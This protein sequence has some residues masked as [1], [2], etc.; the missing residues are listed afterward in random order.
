M[1]GKCG[2]FWPHDVLTIV[3]SDSAGSCGLSPST[4]TESLRS[5]L[6]D[7]FSENRHHVTNL[8]G[9]LAAETYIYDTLK[10]YGMQIY[11]DEFDSEYSGYKGKNIVGIWRGTGTPELRPKQDKPVILGAH[12]DTCRNDPGVDENG[13][14]VAAL[15]EAA[16]VISSLPCL[17]VHSVV[18]AFFDLKCNESGADKAACADGQCGSEHFVEQ[19][20]VPY[21]GY[22][23]VKLSD[24]QGVI[25]M[26]TVLNYNN[27]KGSQ[28][29]PE[30]FENTPLWDEVYVEEEADGMRGNF[31]GIFT[32]QLYDQPLYSI[33]HN[34]WDEE[35]DPQYKRRDV[36]FPY[37]NIAEEADTSTDP[38]WNLYQIGSQDLGS[39]WKASGDIKGLLLSDTA[40]A[41]HRDVGSNEKLPLTNERLGFLKKITNVVI[42]TTMDLAGGRERCHPD[43]RPIENLIPEGFVEGAQLEGKLSLPGGA[44]DYSFVVKTLTLPTLRVDATLSNSTWSLDVS[45]HFWP[46][47][48][49]LALRIQVPKW[50]SLSCRMIGP[51]VESDSGAL[52]SGAIHGSCSGAW[53]EGHVGF[54]LQSS[55][56]RKTAGVGVGNGSLVA[57]GILVGV[58][59]TLLVGAAVWYFRKRRPMRGG[60]S[61]TPLPVST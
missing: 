3:A 27:S 1:N 20:L 55:I 56:G 16:R 34:R 36:L 60:P 9:K 51:L 57:V 14:G 38:Y 24:V 32:R 26:D 6:E 47:E 61:F 43:A 8:P 7:H 50:E 29:A 48:R 31:I 35:C 52:Y 39:F 23:D 11:V 46:R 40:N 42:G 12:Y 59:L 15:M 44:K 53:P 41:R 18:F 19:T 33:F 4:S 49:V 25:I 37:K 5:I 54:T 2:D 30:G 13:S 28:T 45:G 17:L 58:I 21:L 10:S 22:L